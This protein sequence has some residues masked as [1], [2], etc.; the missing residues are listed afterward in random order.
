MEEAAGTKKPSPKKSRPKDVSISK[1]SSALAKAENDTFSAEVFIKHMPTGTNQT[2]SERS[3]VVLTTLGR[4]E[5]HSQD[6]CCLFCGK[7]IEE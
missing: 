2:P 4:D 7:E 5:K 6:V 3:E 1:N